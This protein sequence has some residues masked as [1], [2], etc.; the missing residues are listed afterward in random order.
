MSK[1]QIF[2]PNY[3]VMFLDAVMRSTP[4]RT[5]QQAR[6]VA[7]VFKCLEPAVKAYTKAEQ[8]NKEK[9]WEKRTKKDQFGNDVDEMVIPMEKGEEMERL[10]DE[11][12]S[13]KIEINFDHESLSEVKEA[14]RGIFK[15]KE[16]LESGLSGAQQAEAI[17]ALSLALDMEDE[18]DDEPAEEKDE[19]ETEKE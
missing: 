6:R 19:S 4:Y 8:A 3:A 17:A 14:F 9:C 5:R 15:R 13:Q 16:I 18:T 10:M 1:I 12:K 11:L 2:M 7:V